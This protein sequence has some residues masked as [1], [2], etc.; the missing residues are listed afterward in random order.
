MEELSRHNRFGGSPIDF[1]VS[2]GIAIYPTD[3]NSAKGLL[4]MADRALYRS[5]S[6]GKNR[7]TLHADEKRQSPR[8]DARKLLVF[9]ERRPGDETSDLR[10]ET[11]NLSRSGALVES[12]IP[13]EIGTELEIV[14]HMPHNQADIALKGRVVRLE[15]ASEETGDEARY[16]VG[17]AFLAD[18]EEDGRRLDGFASEVYRPLEHDHALD[19]V[20]PPG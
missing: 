14:I 13:F 8:L 16:H 1:S 3:S 9:R 18:T 15:E 5:K 6:D 10:S 19:G 11:M 17:V 20:D 12:R 4:R 7:I 2:G